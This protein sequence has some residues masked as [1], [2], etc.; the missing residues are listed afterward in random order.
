M[1]DCSPDALRRSWVYRQAIDLCDQLHRPLR[2]KPKPAQRGDHNRSQIDDLE[3]GLESGSLALYRWRSASK[4]PVHFLDCKHRHARLVSPE[5]HAS[6]QLRGNRRRVP[7][8]A[9]PGFGR[10][11]LLPKALQ[12]NKPLVKLSAG[13]CGVCTFLMLLRS[14][15]FGKGG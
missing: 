9:L 14:R 7:S 3:Q 11:Q 15:R 2:E 5:L 4:W 12:L 1:N 13:G 6:N 8:A 10:A